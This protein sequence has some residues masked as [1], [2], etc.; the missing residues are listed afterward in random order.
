VSFFETQCRIWD[1][2]II[3][4]GSDS[5]CRQPRHQPILSCVKFDFLLY[6]VI[7]IHQCYRQTDGHHVVGKAWQANKARYTKNS[8]F[9]RRFSCTTAL[10]R[11]Y[12]RPS[13]VCLVQYRN[14]S[15]GIG[16]CCCNHVN[17]VPP[18]TYSDNTCNTLWV[19]KTKQL[20]FCR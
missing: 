18:P 12:A 4:Y 11:R 19:K 13:S 7:T 3:R 5:A 20:Y 8:T 2:R 6:C 15:R 17:R 14:M 10:L 9:T 1:H 16:T